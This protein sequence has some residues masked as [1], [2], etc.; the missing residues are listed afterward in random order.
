MVA[1]LAKRICEKIGV[2]GGLVIHQFA[3]C[4]GLVA[5]APGAHRSGEILEPPNR[6]KHNMNKAKETSA[7]A[8]DEAAEEATKDHARAQ[9]SRRL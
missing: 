3:R 5:K 4:D 1:T 7:S 8:A 9:P 6:R 2:R